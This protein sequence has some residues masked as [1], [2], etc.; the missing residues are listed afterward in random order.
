M[1]N[2]AKFILTLIGY[3]IGCWSSI[4]LLIFYTKLWFGDV[5]LTEPNKIIL[6]VEIGVWLLGTIVMGYLYLKWLWNNI[7][8]VKHA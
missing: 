5:M 1:K 8:K 2:K 4:L 3:A 7:P 6:S